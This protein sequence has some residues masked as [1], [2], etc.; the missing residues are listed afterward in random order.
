MITPVTNLIARAKSFVDDE[1]TSVQSYILDSTWLAWLNVEYQTL[2]S[3]LL[4]QGLIGPAYTDY[5]IVANGSNQYVYDISITG[6]GVLAIDSIFE[7]FAD[8]GAR[9][10]TPL[11]SGLGRFATQSTPSGTAMYWAAHGTGGSPIIELRPVPSAGS[12]VMRYVPE[13]MIL[14]TASPANGETTTVDLP[15]GIDDRL[16]LGAANRALAKSGTG[17]PVLYGMMKQAEED[18]A[19]MSAGRIVGAAPGARR[20]APWE[21]PQRST[22]GTNLSGVPSNWWWL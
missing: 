13:P 12:Y 3:K 9:F 10:L 19:F 5:P 1:H 22:L 14:V 2:Y 6:T 8:G 21:S 7:S 16:V 15:P 18:M 20:S 11:Q 4:R 17:S